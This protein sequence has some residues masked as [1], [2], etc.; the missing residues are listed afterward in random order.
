VADQGDARLP[1]AGR[2]VAVT[3]ASDQATGL[4]DRLAALGAEPVVVPLIAIAPASD[5]GAALATSLGRVTEYAWVVLTSPNGASSVVA[6][7]A[8]L[9]TGERP[10]IAV[11]GTATGAV[12][13][14]AGIVAD[15]TPPRQL[16]EALVDAFPHHVAGAEGGERLLL[17]V[18]EGAGSN[19]AAGLRA[20]GWSVD[21]VAAYRTVPLRPSSRVLLEA[22]SADAVL[23]AS[24]SA[25]RSWHDAFG[26][27]TPPVVIAIGP[28]TAA[29]ATDL[30]LK[31]DAIAADHSLD[32]LVDSLLILLGAAG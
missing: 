5:D 18:A 25:V 6:A 10:R 16:G 30:G 26:N 31:V 12:F 24:G 9:M 11:V 27:S 28:A 17:A 8:P 23:F 7:L 13:G 20:K 3:R 1:L 15:L 14:Q 32:G 21:V 22:L 4:A 19:V 29:A 2:R